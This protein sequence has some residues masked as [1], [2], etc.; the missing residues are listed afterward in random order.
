LLLD[1]AERIDDD[2]AERMPEPLAALRTLARWLS[3]DTKNTSST[4]SSPA[5][6]FLTQRSVFTLQ[7]DPVGHPFFKH[8]CAAFLAGDEDFLEAVFLDE[9]FL[10]GDDFL[11]ED[12]LAGDEDFFDPDFLAGEEDFLDPDFLA[13]DDFDGV[14]LEE[15]AFDP[16]ALRW[17]FKSPICP[18]TQCPL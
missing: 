8:V 1:K 16:V 11:D 17:F 4:N 14:F 2:K 3:V 9:D 15:E 13:A 5:A 6:A 12:F 10:A 18:R 7:N